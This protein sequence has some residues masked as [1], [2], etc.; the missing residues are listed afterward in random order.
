VE[1]GLFLVRLD[2]EV[3]TDERD[4]DLA[5]HRDLPAENATLEG[6]GDECQRGRGQRRRMS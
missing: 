5:L 2:G 3:P 6:E 1:V 4:F